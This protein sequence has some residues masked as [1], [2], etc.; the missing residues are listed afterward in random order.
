MHAMQCIGPHYANMLPRSHKKHFMGSGIV[1]LSKKD[2]KERFFTLSMCPWTAELSA[3][4]HANMVR[5]VL[6]RWDIAEE[7]ITYANADNCSTMIACIRDHFPGWSKLPCGP[8][9]L[10]LTVSECIW[11]SFHRDGTWAGKGPRAIRDFIVR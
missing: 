8:H 6:K 4:G 1:Y 9:W 5:A 3:E 7:L 11:G 2:F 10:H